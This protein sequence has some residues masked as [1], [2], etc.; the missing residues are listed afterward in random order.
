MWHQARAP[1]ARRHSG[2]DRARGQGHRPDPGRPFRR[3]D[4]VC[5]GRRGRDPRHGCVMSGADD[6]APE[7]EEPE[8]DV[9]FT[10]EEPPPYPWAKDDD[11]RRRTFIME[12]VPFDA[13]AEPKFIVDT[14]KQV[15][16][17][18]RTGEAL[19]PV[20]SNPLPPRLRKTKD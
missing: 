11:E 9:D 15:E 7:G 10:P 3:L 14:W 12:S 1:R 16:H 2:T 18:I 5:V 6:K 17:W 20:D 19:V 13:S 8:L 4:R